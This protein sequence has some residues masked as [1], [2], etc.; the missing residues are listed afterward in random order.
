MSV[1]NF[2]PALALALTAASLLSTLPLAAAE[3]T[4]PAVEFGKLEDLERLSTPVVDPPSGEAQEAIDRMNLPAGFKAQLFAAEP[5]FANP[6][7][8]ALDERG[9]VFVSETHRY[10]SSTLDIRGYMW[11]LEDDLD[12]RNQADWLASIERNFGPEGVAELSKES[13]IIR[14]IEDTDGDGAAD[15]SSIYADNFR[16]PLDGVA[17]GVLPYRGLA[18]SQR[19]RADGRQIKA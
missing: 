8:F 5:M 15:K 14:L 2:R 1:L 6:V 3:N 4:G 16:S 19:L 18:L 13:E 10:G 17:S 7:A 9:R 12:N 11:T